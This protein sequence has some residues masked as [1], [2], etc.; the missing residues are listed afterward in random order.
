MDS[1]TGLGSSKNEFLVVHGFRRYQ[2][3]PEIDVTP[4]EDTSRTNVT[5]PWIGKVEVSNG[6]SYGRD[7]NTGTNLKPFGEAYENSSI[8]GRGLAAPGQV[9]VGNMNP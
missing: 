3:A 1:H 8:V 4:P 7:P 2:M 9:G 6:E 5:L